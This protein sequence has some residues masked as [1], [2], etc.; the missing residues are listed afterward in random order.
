MSLRFNLLDDVNGVHNAFD[1]VR[2]GV[3]FV[4]FTRFSLH[5]VGIEISVI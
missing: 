3:F 4:T 1:A 5:C 2:D